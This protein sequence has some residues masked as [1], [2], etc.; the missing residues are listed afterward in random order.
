[1]RKIVAETNL[2]WNA[3]ANFLKPF[4]FRFPTWADW[5]GLAVMAIAAPM[6]AALIHSYCVY[7]RGIRFYN[8]EIGGEYF[9]PSGTVGPTGLLA[10]FNLMLG[11]GILGI[12]TFLALLPFRKRPL[13]RWLVWTG[14]I[15][16]WTAM[17]FQMEITLR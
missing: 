1:M 16:L 10:F 15:F 11:C 6:N 4:Q 13:I 12:P 3:P 5:L 17:F 7:E 9:H 8:A 14:S 2:R